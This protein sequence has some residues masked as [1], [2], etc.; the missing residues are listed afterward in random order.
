VLPPSYEEYLHKENEKNKQDD[1]F[2][3]RDTSCIDRSS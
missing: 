3:I 1:W 2:S